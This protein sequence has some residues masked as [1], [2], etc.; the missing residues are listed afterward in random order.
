METIVIAD[1]DVGSKLKGL[2]I[3]LEIL[4]PHLLFESFQLQC[5]HIFPREKRG[6]EEGLGNKENALY[7]SR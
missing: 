1:T 2:H 3:S 7:I 6:S 4:T 5:A